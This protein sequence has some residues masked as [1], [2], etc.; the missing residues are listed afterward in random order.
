MTSSQTPGSAIYSRRLLSLYD[1]FVLGFSNR[2]VWRCPARELLAFY[3]QHVSA[4]HLD[5]GVGTGYFLDRC[6]FPSPSPEIALLDLNESSL[7]VTAERIRRYHPLK[8]CANI[9]EPLKLEVPPFQSIGMN[10][11]LHCLAGDMASKAVVF[12]NVKPFLAPGGVVFGATILA[13]GV[14][15]GWLA[16]RFMDVYNRKG[17]FGNARDSL[18]GLEAALEASFPRYTVSVRGC[19]ALFAGHAS[20]G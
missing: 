20:A 12:R 9:L 19:A 13:A 14:K 3:N 4:R 6:R 5:V 11:L 15:R 17:V 10:Y 8:L 1:P 16:R 2:F 18:E 7:E